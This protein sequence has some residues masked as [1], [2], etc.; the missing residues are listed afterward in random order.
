MTAAFARITELHDEQLYLTNPCGR[1]LYRWLLRRY[2]AGKAQEF[3]IKEFQDWSEYNRRRPRPY[4]LSWIWKA[5]DELINIGLLSI[6]KRYSRHCVKVVAFHP[7]GAEATEKKTSKKSNKTFKKSNKTFKKS[8]KTSEADLEQPQGKDSELRPSNIEHREI[9][10]TA[11]THPTHPVVVGEIV[12]NFE[13]FQ[14]KENYIAPNQID[15]EIQHRLIENNEELY[16]QAPPID[17]DSHQGKVLLE[18][19]E[20]AGIQLHPKLKQVVIYSTFD[21]VR[22]ALNVVKEAK[23]KGNL[24]NPAGLFVEALKNRWKPNSSVNDD[25]SLEF[26]RWY[27]HAIEVGLVENIPLNFLSKDRCNQPLVR[28]TKPGEFGSPYT[29]V[30]WRDLLGF[31]LDF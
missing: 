28:W 5:M 13:V 29:L 21:V 20:D 8:N 14:S 22:D 12:Q 4:C 7:D 19:I 2:P 10:R 31:D 15:E 24:K 27:P 30:C 11:N 3:D 23:A 25:F 16:R 17:K 18:Q 1:L 9:Q 6:T 26:L